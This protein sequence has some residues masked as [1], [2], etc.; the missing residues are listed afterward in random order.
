MT[1]DDRLRDELMGLRRCNP[2]KLE[3]LEYVHTAK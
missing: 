1:K 3:Y 2:A